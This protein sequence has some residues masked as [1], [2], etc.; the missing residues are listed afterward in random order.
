MLNCARCWEVR[1]MANENENFEKLLKQSFQE[2]DSRLIVPEIPD[3]QAIFEAKE[4][5]KG[6]VIP[7]RTVR[8]IAAAAIVFVVGISAFALGGKLGIT[9]SK[10]A[11]LTDIAKPASE[12]SMGIGEEP[13][14]S[15]EDAEIPYSTEPTEEEQAEEI[16]PAE[17]IKTESK[18]VEMNGVNGGSTKAA[19]TFFYQSLRH[20]FDEDGLDESGQ[21]AGTSSTT[22]FTDVLSNKRSVTVNADTDSVSVTLYDTSGESE[23]LSAFWV[24]GNFI[25]SAHKGEEYVIVIEKKVTKEEFENGYY[26]PMVGDVE[27]GTEEFSENRIFVQEPIS[28]GIIRMTVFLNV[29]RGSYEIEAVLQ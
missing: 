11:Q 12:P 1:I 19:E 16:S 9:A 14:E 23:I 17:E 26:L 21:K 4:Q 5:K 15:L 20:F 10:E 29:E 3:A 13:E 28:E 25:S 22:S 27:K 2:L 7:F 18:N 6:K 24:E 8:V